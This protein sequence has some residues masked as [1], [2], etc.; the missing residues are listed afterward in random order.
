LR[1]SRFDINGANGLDFDPHQGSLPLGNL[2]AQDTFSLTD[3][4]SI[5]LGGK[6]E[7]GNYTGFSFM[8]SGRVSWQIAKGAMI[9]GAIS[10]AVRSSTPFDHDVRETLGTTLFVTGS[11]DFKT[12]KLTAYELG[13]RFQPA[14]NLTFSVSGYY[15]HYDDLRSIEVSPVTGFLPLRWGNGMVGHGYGV[16]AW[17]DYGFTSWWRLSAGADLLRESFGFAAGSS[18]L[19]PQQQG[20]DPRHQYFLRSS[21]T[22]GGGFTIDADFRAIG[23]RPNPHVPAY[24]ELGGRV[25]WAVA[26]RLE[27]SLAGQNLL[28]KSHVEYAPPS[29]LIPRKLLAGAQ[30][31]F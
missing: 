30:W 31:R 22:L 16:E 21:I 26:R 5:T 29:N 4:L 25:A 15:N 10:R 27:L 12:E 19:L 14:T 24:A 6:L 7:D 11:N 20:D 8:P 18:G 2:F 1:V 3:A 23:A 13:G 9:W 17:A 28:H